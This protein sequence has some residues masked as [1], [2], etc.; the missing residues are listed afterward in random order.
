[1]ARPAVDQSQEALRIVRR[2]Y[3]AG[4]ATPTDVIEAETARTRAEQRYVSAQIESMS[5]LARLAWVMGD[6]PGG[7]CMLEDMPARESEAPAEPPAR[8]PMPRPVP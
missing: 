7:L 6:P 4:T 1:M 5:A 8:L 3:R 2:R